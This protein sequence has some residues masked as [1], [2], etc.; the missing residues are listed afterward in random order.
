MT[1]KT[2]A[3]QLRFLVCFLVLTLVFE[4]LVRKLAGTAMKDVVFFAKDLLTL[5]IGFVVFRA[6]KPG[7]IRFLWNTYLIVAALFVPL[8]FRTAFEDPKLALFGVERYLLFPVVAFA[9]FLAFA[10]CPKERIARFLFW[11]ALL[12]IPTT[13]VALL[14]AKLPTD[15]WLNLGV[16]GESLETFMRA[17]KLRVSS[18]FPFISQYCMFLNTEVFII[19]ASAY[20]LK[21]LKGVWKVAALSTVPLLIVGTFI[22]GSRQAVVGN[23]WIVVIAMALVT[24][25]GKGGAL[26]YLWMLIGFLFMAYVSVKILYPQGFEI[27][28]E[29]EEGKIS[30]VGGEVLSRT[31]D[32][33]F[34][35]TNGI[36]G[37]PPTLFGYGLG[38]MS[39][40]SQQLSHYAASWRLTAGWTE[41]DYATTLF[42]GGLYL[43]MLWYAFRYFV[44]YKTTIRFLSGIGS[45]LIV[46]AA[47][48]QGYVI[49]QGFTATLGIQPPSAIWW[50][51]AVGMSTVFWWKSAEA[52][53]GAIDPPA[54]P[55]VSAANGP[56]RIKGRSS[57][58]E[59]L[60]SG[61]TR[62]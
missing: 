15:H 25:K 22:T 30:G 45:D 57:Y 27:Y 48:C 19:M 37:A 29:R 1:G 59:R 7:P 8:A 58:A 23:I 3:R 12:I 20:H 60:H 5:A 52:P 11:G 62:D 49:L 9:T 18:T 41:T 34:G 33:F 40:G 51:L 26:A 55:G 16:Q 42:E 31:W 2:P 28:L 44:I 4:G 13:L 50:W 61:S 53:E 56:R 38:V 32:A 14:Q 17:G 21:Q 6:D 36:P 54:A 43:I 46:P 35:W 47:F 10:D 24:L 39:N